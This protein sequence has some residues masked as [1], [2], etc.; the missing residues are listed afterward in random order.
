MPTITVLIDSPPTARYHAATVNALGHAIDER[1]D[2]DS[3]TIDVVHTDAISTIG[4]AVVIGPGTP[5]NDP[6]AA[7]AVITS[8]RERGVPLVAT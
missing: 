3:F 4:D 8:A 1:D 7:E 2:R 5:Y 6:R